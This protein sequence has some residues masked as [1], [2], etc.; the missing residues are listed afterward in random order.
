V[1]SNEETRRTTAVMRDL[2]D[3]EHAD[4]SCCFD[5]FPV[6]LL[7]RAKN[8]VYFQYLNNRNLEFWEKNYF[9]TI[10]MDIEG[11]E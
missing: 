8:S 6:L 2:S 1:W 7:T 5:K 10:I 4:V 11:R 3:M 9:F